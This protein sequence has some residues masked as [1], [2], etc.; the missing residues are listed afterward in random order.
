MIFPLHGSMQ[1]DYFLTTGRTFFKF[2]TSYRF[3]FG[4][5]TG[6]SFFAQSGTPLSEYAWTSYGA[7]FLSPR[8]SYGRTP[9]IWDLNAR[10]M[11]YLDFLSNWQTK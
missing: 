4:L 10:V 5:T 11:Y 2:S 8:S 1:P 3:S 9:A 6:I 7:T